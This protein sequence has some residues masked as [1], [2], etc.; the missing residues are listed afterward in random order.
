MVVPSDRA[1]DVPE[2]FRVLSETVDGHY[3]GVNAGG[4]FNFNRH[5]GPFIAYSRHSDCG[6]PITDIVIRDLDAPN[7]DNDSANANHT[8]YDSASWERMSG[9]LNSKSL[10]H[11]LEILVRRG[12][13]NNDRESPSPSQS[14]SPIVDLALCNESKSEQVP[15]GFTALLISLNE[16]APHRDRIWW[17]CV[18]RNEEL[19]TDETEKRRRHRAPAILDRYHRICIKV[20]TA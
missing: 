18:A 9:N 13:A 10:G 4:Y 8:D 2:N 20:D 19:E 5:S 15:F 17:L 12:G 6:A 1:S 14:Q 7:N 16:G 11:R 3:G